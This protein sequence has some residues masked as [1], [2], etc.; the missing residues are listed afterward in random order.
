MYALLQNQ[1]D[2][3][4]RTR[5]SNLKLPDNDFLN[6][7]DKDNIKKFNDFLRMFFSLWD[8]YLERISP[9]ILQFNSKKTSVY[10]K[11]IYAEMIAE[12]YGKYLNDLAKLEVPLFI[13]KSFNLFFNSIKYKSIFFNLYSVNPDN[14]DLGDMQGKSE[15]LEEKFWNDIYKE[16]A[17]IESYLSV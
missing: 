16:D 15:F 8:K 2:L 11:E 14:K 1:V 4:F 10:F 6:E 9:L 7:E 17:E 12:Q 3:M 13:N 5:I